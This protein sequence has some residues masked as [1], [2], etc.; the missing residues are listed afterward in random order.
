MEVP[1]P[2][3]TRGGGCYQNQVHYCVDGSPLRHA[4]GLTLQAGIEGNCISL[5][6][7][8]R[9][10]RFS[11]HRTGVAGGGTG[12]GLDPSDSALVVI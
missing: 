4:S 12:A 3:S 6:R 11:D 1:E 8:T 2:S 7:S 5:K 10:T 9:A